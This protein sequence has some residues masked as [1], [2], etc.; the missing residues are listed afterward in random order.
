MKYI[1]R[2]LLFRKHNDDELKLVGHGRIMDT[3]KKYELAYRRVQEFILYLYLLFGMSVYCY[4][5]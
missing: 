2:I 1:F 5:G 4:T 3:Y